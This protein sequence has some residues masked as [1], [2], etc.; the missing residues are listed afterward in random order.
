MDTTETAEGA[1]TLLVVQNCGS[2][3]RSEKKWSLSSEV[4]SIMQVCRRL[5]LYVML[6]DIQFSSG[7]CISHKLTQ[8][9]QCAL[10]YK[11]KTPYLR[12]NQ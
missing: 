5:K 12:Q 4:L 10:Y 2:L 3:S 11:L 6:V 9:S 7:L 1:I 8:A